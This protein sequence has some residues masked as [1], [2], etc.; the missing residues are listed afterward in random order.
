MRKINEANML[1][2]S[3]FMIIIKY[4]IITA[5]KLTNFMQKIKYSV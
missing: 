1:K 5:L 2:F 4:Q 3:P